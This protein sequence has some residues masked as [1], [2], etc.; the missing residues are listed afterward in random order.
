MNR[1]STLVLAGATSLS[2]AAP[3]RAE[4]PPEQAEFV[5]ANILAVFYHEL[6]HAVI[7]LM[8]LPIFGQEED[9]A[10][11]MAVLLIDAPFDEETAQ[12]L[13][14]DSAFGFINDT[15]GRDDIAWWD[16]HGP[17]EQRYYNHV[18]LFFGANPEEREGLADE[19]GLP[20]ERADSCPD[21]YQLAAE[22]WGAVF[23]EMA[24]MAG[25]A[26]MTLEKG[27]GEDAA[28]ANEILG[29]EIEALNREFGLPE[30]LLVKVGPCGE[31]NAFYDPQERSI[32]ICEEFAPYLSD[33]FSRL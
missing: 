10:D 30:P 11:V 6:G 29:A 28:V 27:S 4:T 19:L 13:A 32:T 12:S 8:G 18:C 14:Y 24:E 2:L 17:D 1:V 5:S 9:A 16:V 26:T 31:P 25:Q 7:D 3:V 20:D 33:L 23:D 15:E 22:S 21:E